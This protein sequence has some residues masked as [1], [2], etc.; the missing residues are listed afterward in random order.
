MKYLY[1]SRDNKIFGGV[2]GGIGEYFDI[3]P[4]IVR[5]GFV[6][7]LFMSAIVPGVLAYVVALI[8]IPKKPIAVESREAHSHH[9]GSQGH[10][11]HEAHHTA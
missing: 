10:G 4:V 11:H 7:L 6:L 3:D 5:V 8:L 2:M 9:H 1:R